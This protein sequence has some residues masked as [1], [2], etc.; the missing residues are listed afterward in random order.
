MAIEYF[1]N[2][3]TGDS[4]ETGRGDYCMSNGSVAWTCPG[5]GNQTVVELGAYVDL[6][7]GSLRLAIYDASSNFIAQGDAVI[8]GTHAL[9][10]ETHT[11]FHNAAGADITPTLMGGANYKLCMSLTAGA[12]C[13]CRHTAGSAGQG[14]A[15]SGS[16]Y[17]GGYPDPLPAQDDNS[18]IWCIRCG[19]EAAAGGGAVVPIIMA[20]MNQF[21]G[22]TRW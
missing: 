22:G 18:R 11:A 2:K 4:D 8:T 15:T 14:K 1:G 16:D 13:N 10:W 20:Q 17:T 7:S 5:T 3:S 21:G 6:D 19:G 9:N 12:T